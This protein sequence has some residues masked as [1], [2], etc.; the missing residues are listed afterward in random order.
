MK[1]TIKFVS[2]N[3]IIVF[4]LLLSVNCN[5]KKQNKNPY[6]LVVISDIETYTKLIKEKP[7]KTLVDIEKII[8]DIV[9]DIRYATK[10]NFTKQQIYKSPK[11]FV[12]KPVA[13]ALVKIQNELNGKGIALKIY[14]AYRPYSATVKFYEIYPD[15]NFVASPKTGSIHNRGYAVDVSLISLASQKELE[16]PTPFDD[17][18]EKAAH[19]YLDLPDTALKNRQILKNVMTKHGFTIYNEEWWH[20]TYK[21][22]KN[23]ELMDIPFSSLN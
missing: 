13:D 14:D 11:A 15:K 2:T 22:W 20:Y 21:D 1:K 9:L 6:G 12:R 3:I 5:Q 18:T 10:N 8:P 4:L 16:M 23:F 7:E 19:S 17:F